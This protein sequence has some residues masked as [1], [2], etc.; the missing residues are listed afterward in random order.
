MLKGAFWFL[1]DSR[2]WADILGER[3]DVDVLTPQ[4]VAALFPLGSRN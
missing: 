4:Q 2:V 3:A 1:A